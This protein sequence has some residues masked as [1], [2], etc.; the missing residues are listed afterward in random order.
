M[1][2]IWLLS[3]ELI[4]VQYLFAQTNT[5]LGLNLEDEEAEIEEH[6]E[7]FIEEEEAYL[8]TQVKHS[9]KLFMVKKNY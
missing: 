7:G 2:I 3:G 6:D 1:R 5:P 8:K 9:I 4:G